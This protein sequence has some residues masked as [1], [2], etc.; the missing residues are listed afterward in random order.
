MTTFSEMDKHY[1]RHNKGICMD[2]GC[3]VFPWEY[4]CRSCRNKVDE[5]V[6]YFCADCEKEA[7][8]LDED[9]LCPECA[10]KADAYDEMVDRVKDALSTPI[11]MAQM[12]KSILTKDKEG[13]D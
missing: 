6:A 12:V 9:D 2:C 8:K 4:R 1:D 11:D 13:K 10:A 7:E 5:D 3:T